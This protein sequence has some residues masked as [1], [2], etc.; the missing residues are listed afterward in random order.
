MMNGTSA[1]TAIAAIEPITGFIATVTQ[2]EIHGSSMLVIEG[3]LRAPIP[4]FPGPAPSSLYSSPH[5]TASLPN[6][7]SQSI[8]KEK[9]PVTE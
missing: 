6:I 7:L 3:F 1:Q 8:I 2:K 9:S 5:P 4:A